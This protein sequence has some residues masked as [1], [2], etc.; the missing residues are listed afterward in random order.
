MKKTTSQH[1]GI[2]FVQ[3]IPAALLVSCVTARAQQPI[4]VDSSQPPLKW[5]VPAGWVEVAPGE[6]RLA[7]FTIKGQNSKQADVSV[8][9]LPGNA[10]GDINNVNRWRGQLSLPP[11]TAEALSG[12]SQKTDV[13]GEPADLY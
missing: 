3:M 6:M 7:S 8:V 10:G 12:I 4:L 13:G 2:R 9:T 5:I 1:L 11:V